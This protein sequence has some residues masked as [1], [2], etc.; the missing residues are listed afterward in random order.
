MGIGLPGLLHAYR[1]SDGKLL[2][3]KFTKHS[4]NQAVAAGR[5]PSG[6]SFIVLGMGDNPQLVVLLRY[7][8]YPS[9]LA[10]TMHRIS[11]IF[12]KLFSTPK[13]S[14]VA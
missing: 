6:R 1:H 14:A 7:T 12:P 3:V 2:W 10:L 4:A 5:T 9:W 11:L 13:P 8:G